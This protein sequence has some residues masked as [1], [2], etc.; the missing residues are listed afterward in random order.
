MT[1]EDAEPSQQILEHLSLRLLETEAK[2]VASDPKLHLAVSL[3]QL[4]VSPSAV[5]ER[6]GSL[7]KT[8]LRQMLRP[9]Q[10]LQL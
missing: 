10:R 3:K 1:T 6:A 8:H 9:T 2:D 5:L 7:G 4:Q